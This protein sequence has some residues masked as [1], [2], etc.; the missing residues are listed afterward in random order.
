M[1]LAAPKAHCHSLFLGSAPR[2]VERVDSELKGP[3]SKDAHFFSSAHYHSFPTAKV[4]IHDP[5]PT[6]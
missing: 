1:E 6:P 2:A 5:Q 4:I 3:E